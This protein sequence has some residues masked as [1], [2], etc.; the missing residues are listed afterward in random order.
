MW[1]RQS[2]GKRWPRPPVAALAVFV[3]ALMLA[4]G[5]LVLVFGAPR[6]LVVHT[7]ALGAYPGDLT[8]DPQGRY[9]LLSTY[10]SDPRIQASAPGPLLVFDLH[11]GTLTHSV[12][13]GMVPLTIVG[14]AR[15]ARF[16][17][18]GNGALTFVAMSTGRVSSAV[19]SPSFAPS[20]VV[21]DARDRVYGLDNGAAGAA[22]ASTSSRRARAPCSSR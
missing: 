21:D 20:I 18:N 22:R 15:R 12:D 9:A 7:I 3:L 13:L 19:T 11:A 6:G 4:L 8:L 2:V 1:G 5:G 10:A 16:V 17:V 14:D